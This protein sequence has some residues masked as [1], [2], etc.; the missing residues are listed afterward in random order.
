MK[1]KHEQSTWAN[2]FTIKYRQHLSGRKKSVKA[3]QEFFRAH[4]SINVHSP[5]KMHSD[6]LGKEKESKGHSQTTLTTFCPLLTT[7]PPLA[8]VTIVK[9]FLIKGETCI[10][11][12]MVIKV[13]EFQVRD[14]K[15][16]RVLP[17]NQHIQWK[18]INEFWELVKVI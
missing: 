17:E 12:T 4:V 14:T 8:L 2:L 9:E 11:W 10:L 1:V 5:I 15:L 13:M 6:M 16:E 3:S 7:C 18:E